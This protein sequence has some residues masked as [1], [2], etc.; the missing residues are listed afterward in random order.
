MALTL[1]EVSDRLDRLPGS[2]FHAKILV[3]A[4]LSLFFDT[5]DHVIFGFVLASLRTIWKFDVRTVGLI[6]AIGMFGYLVGSFSC[7]FIA[8]RIGRKKTILFTLIFYSLFSALRGLSND[9]ARLALLNFLTLIFI[10][11]ENS[12]VPPYLAELWPARIRGKLVGWMMGFF[13]LGIALA[14]VWA[15]LIIPNLGWRWALL[16]TGPFA[17]IGGLIRSSLP[18]SPRWLVRTGNVTQAESVLRRIEAEVEKTVGAPL[19]VVRE[20]PSRASTQPTVRSRDLLSPA[21]R[22]TTLML[23]AL[24]FAEYGVLYAFQTFVPTI[25]SAEGYSIVNSFRYSVVIYGA[26]IPGYVL[27]GQAVEWLDRKYSAL[28]SFAA[29]G[30]FGTLFGLSTRPLEIVTF[31]GLTAFFLAVGSTSIYAYTPELYPTEVR[32]TGMGIASAWGRVG[33]VM[34]ILTFGFFFAARGKSL[35]FIMSDSTLLI[36]SIAVACFGPV[37]RGRP[38]EDTARGA[39]VGLLATIR[40]QK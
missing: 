29:I 12:T 3:I 9:V 16:L 4:A 18:E 27:G 22:R 33:A 8:D 24:W 11:A 25:L 30:I 2:R 32:A 13:G 20:R 15:L 40:S 6:S 7:G 34:Q 38:L 36:A 14:P 35:L 10:G 17:L 1:E 31:G 21:Y 26:V 23:W 39:G 28:L 5:L 37:T 19:P